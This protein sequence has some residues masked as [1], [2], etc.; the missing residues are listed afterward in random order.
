MA[1]AMPGAAAVPA[2]SPTRPESAES[3]EGPDATLMKWAFSAVTVASAEAIVPDRMAPDLRGSRLAR[4]P[5]AVTLVAESLACAYEPSA[6]CVEQT[7]CMGVAS[8]AKHVVVGARVPGFD[9]AFI[10]RPA[11]C[12]VPGASALRRNFRRNAQDSASASAR[13][14]GRR[15]AGSL[16]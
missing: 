8:G 16:G 1:A 11:V 4:A 9:Q 13:I 15:F 10:H 14:L 5:L 2:L 12:S 6:R 3:A 7:S